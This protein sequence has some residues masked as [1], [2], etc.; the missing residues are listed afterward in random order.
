[1]P[2]PGWAG[3]RGGRRRPGAQLEAEPEEP[4]DSPPSDPHH[5]VRR[6]PPRGPLTGGLLGPVG[7]RTT[8]PACPSLPRGH[9]PSTCGRRL[10]LTAGWQQV[11]RGA[12]G[13]GSGAAG[14]AHGLSPDPG[15]VS[16]TV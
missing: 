6:L 4:P 16:P 14:R 3:R 2:Q 12:G 11:Q 9:R 7:R 8:P 10:D 15:K 5:R 1:M 13:A